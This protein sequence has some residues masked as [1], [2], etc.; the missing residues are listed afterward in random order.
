M[1]SNTSK[2]KKQDEL[3][4]DLNELSYKE[5]LKRL[6]YNSGQE[7]YFFFKY[8][9]EKNALLNEIKE[10]INDILEQKN[11]KEGDQRLLIRFTN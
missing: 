1:G 6:V 9:I 8:I 3:S 2:L 7:F 4:I 5:A 11:K 10:S